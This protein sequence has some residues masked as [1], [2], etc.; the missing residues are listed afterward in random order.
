M[1]EAF[2]YLVAG[3]AFAAWASRIAQTRGIADTHWSIWPV[4]ILAWPWFL[5]FVVSRA[6][7]WRW[8]HRRGR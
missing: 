6:L 4:L 3:A 8:S 5:V 2:A 7:H 1:T